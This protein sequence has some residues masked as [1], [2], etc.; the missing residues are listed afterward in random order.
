MAGAKGDTITKVG[1]KGQVVLRKAIRDALNIT[2]GMPV[3]Q[4]ITRDGVLI[5]PID[6]EEISKMLQELDVI[7][8]KVSKHWKGKQDA[9]AAISEDRR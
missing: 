5:K 9:V 6:A 1:P 4:Q 3:R 7:A 2:P 8:T